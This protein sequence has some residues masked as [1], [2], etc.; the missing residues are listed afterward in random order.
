MK[1]FLNVLLKVLK[2]EYI[3][4]LTVFINNNAR[5]TYKHAMQPGQVE[6]ITKDVGLKRAAY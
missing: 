6:G 3:F 4:I 5:D 2:H 1:A